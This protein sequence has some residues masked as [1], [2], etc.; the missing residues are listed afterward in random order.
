MIARRQ[1]VAGTQLYTATAHHIH[2]VIDQRAHELGCVVL[3]HRG[4]H[5]GRAVF[6]GTSDQFTQR[7]QRVSTRGN[8]G[9]GFLYTLKLANFHVELTADSRVCTYHQVAHRTARRGQRRQGNTATGA[10]AFDEHPPALACHRGTA[11][12]PV[13]GNEHVVPLDGSVHEGRAGVVPAAYF[14]TRMRRRQQGAGDA[15]IGFFRISQ[16]AFGVLKLERQSDYGGH[17]CE[18]N[19]ALV[20][21]EAKANNLLA[22]EIPLADHAEVGNCS[23]IRADFRARETKTG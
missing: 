5:R 11:D 14:H 18:R 13:D 23:S 20:E 3:G 19:P 2:A 17:R 12:D 1:E 7:L 6:Q 4:H 21:I 9:G 10:Q 16:Q 8:L 22:L 15:V